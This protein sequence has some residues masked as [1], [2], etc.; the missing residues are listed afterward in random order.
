MR[1][2]ADAAPPADFEER[3]DDVVV[4]RV[5]VETQLDDPTRLV[6]VVVRLLDRGHIRDLRELC[7]RL[8]LNVDHNPRGNVVDHHRPVTR[9][10]NRLE[11]LHDRPRRRLVVVRRHDEEAVRA[12]LVRLLGQVN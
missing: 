3:V 1:V 11:M 12:C 7:H 5:E 2:H 9:G 8:G 10:R 6:E 4:A